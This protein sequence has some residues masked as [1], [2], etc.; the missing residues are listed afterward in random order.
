MKVILSVPDEDYSRNAVYTKFD[1]YVLM[2]NTSC[3]RYTSCVQSLK[4]TSVTKFKIYIS[5]KVFSAKNNSRHPFY[6]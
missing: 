3:S 6:L 1:V 4:S 5:D 2:R